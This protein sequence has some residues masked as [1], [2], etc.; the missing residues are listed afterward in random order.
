[1]MKKYLYLLL[2]A[3]LVLF[4]LLAL[5]RRKLFHK[6]GEEVLGR[7]N[8]H[9]H[10]ISPHRF[11]EMHAREPGLQLV[12]LRDRR[13]FTNGHLPGALHLPSESLDPDVIHGFF[14][15]KGAGWVIYAE[16]TYEAEK[17]WI[18]FT[19]MGLEHLFVLETGPGLDLL[20]RQW[21]DDSSRVMMLDEIP[22]FTFR[23]DSTVS[24]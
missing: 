17:Y 23:P 20:I 13:A 18:L 16:K 10:I 19:Q 8:Q 5:P 6:S 11:K 15:G 2:A 12:D 24:F 21:D 7:I 14:R 9:T 3:M 1:M 22:T 4:M